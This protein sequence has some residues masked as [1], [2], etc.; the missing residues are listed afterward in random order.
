MTAKIA[1]REID[2]LIFDVHGVFYDNRN[3]NQ[4]F[5]PLQLSLA[6]SLLSGKENLSEGDVFSKRQEY[7]QLARQIGSWRRA[8]ITMGGVSRN[9][10]RA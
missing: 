7:V 8:F 1:G 3:K 6:Q 5:T 4:I 9:I 2:G 10:C